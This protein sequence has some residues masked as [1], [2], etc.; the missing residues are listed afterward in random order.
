MV[1][2]S[3]PVAVGSYV[4]SRLTRVRKQLDRLD[5]LMAEEI[6][7][8]RLDRLASAQYRLSEQERIMAGR[9]LPGSISRVPERVKPRAPLSVAP[10][11]IAKPVDLP[12]PGGALLDLPDA[13]A[14]CWPLSVRY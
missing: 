3:T 14:A 2:D 7:P 1:A 13:P 12:A 10:L 9:P 8:Q 11:G 6:D 5:R 4:L